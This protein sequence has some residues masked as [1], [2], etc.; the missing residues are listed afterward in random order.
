[1][2]AAVSPP[3]LTRV[4]EAFEAQAKLERE[5]E[6]LDY[7]EAGRL[8]FSA[9]MEAR[10]ADAKGAAE[11]LRMGFHK[12]RR[13]GATH[14]VARLAQIEDL[15]ARLDGYRQELADYRADLAGYRARSLWL[16]Q[17][18][19][20]RAEANLASVA[21]VLVV[22]RARLID[23]RA[24]FEALP[25]LPADPGSVPEPVAHEALG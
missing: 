4:V 5:A 16:D 22:L 20:D 6:D 7:D 25:R 17:P 18:F 8:K 1:V 13:Y 14:I 15:V 24:Q 11:A 3:R 23:T 10:V 2:R 19:A 9:E 12:Q 21:D